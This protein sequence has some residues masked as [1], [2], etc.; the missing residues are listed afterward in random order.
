MCS[1]AGS[2]RSGTACAQRAHASDALIIVR[3]AQLALLER[4]I[5]LTMRSSPGQA[6]E[7]ARQHVA[8]RAPRLL[9]YVDPLVASIGALALQTGFS[10]RMLTTV[11]GQDVHRRAVPSVAGF[12]AGEIDKW[13]APPIAAQ[14]R[15]SSPEPLLVRVRGAR[16]RASG[17]IPK[18][19]S[20]V[21]ED[22]IAAVLSSLETEREINFDHAGWAADHGLAAISV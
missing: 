19:T 11:T 5:H 9:A 4:R 12:D 2:Q 7:A 22:R 14:V 17:F 1:A 6:A 15:D 16:R 8:D 18:R 21:T 10:A 20:L 13:I 3:G